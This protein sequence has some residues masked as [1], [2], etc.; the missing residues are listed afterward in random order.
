M[1]RPIVSLVLRAGLAIVVG[2]IRGLT[3][4]RSPGQLWLGR[5]RGTFLETKLM[6]RILSLDGGGVKGAFLAALEQ[7]TG[8]AAVVYFDLIVGTSTGGMTWARSSKPPTTS[9]TT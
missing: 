6:F 7:D 9:W 4:P 8:K 3:P 1:L 5:D 2:R